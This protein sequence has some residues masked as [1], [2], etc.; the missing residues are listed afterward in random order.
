MVVLKWDG[1]FLHSKS[2]R[3]IACVKVSIESPLYQHIDICCSLVLTPAVSASRH[4][5][6]SSRSL[7]RESQHII[8]HRPT[9]DVTLYKGLQNLKY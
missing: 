7:S 8:T 6:V 2:E 9:S 1:V 4:F 3:F 5:G